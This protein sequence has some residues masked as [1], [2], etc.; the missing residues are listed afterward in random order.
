MAVQAALGSDIALVFDE[1]TPFHADRE[2]TARSTERTHRWLDRCLAWH[3]RAGARAPGASSG[4]SRAACTRTCAASRPQAVAAAGVDGIAIG[5]TLGRD[6]GEMREACRVTGRRC[7]RPSARATCSASA[8]PT[9]CSAGSGSGSTSSTAP[10]RPGSA[11]HGMALAPL[12]EARWRFD[13][14]QPRSPPS[15]EPLVEG[16]PC[17][18]CAAALPAPTCTTCC[19]RARPPPR[20]CSPSTTSPSSSGWSPARA[21]GDPGG[22]LRRVSARGVEGGAAPWDATSQ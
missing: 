8:S 19:G 15:D 10:C 4:S 5:G 13:L 6:K 14:P 17:P 20:G 11:R 7:C 12:P 2:Y 3:E 18:T 1:C 21:A 22:A 16:C 9:T